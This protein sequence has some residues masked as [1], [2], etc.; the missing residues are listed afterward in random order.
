[1][2]KLP[3]VPRADELIDKA[4]RR[5][6]KKAKN[7]R[8]KRGKKDKKLKDAE[9]ARVN[10]I[11]S[12]IDSDLKKIVNNFPSY[13][14]LPSFYQRLLDLQ[15]DKN[16]YKRCLGS[17]DGVIPIN[18]KLR[19][20]AIGEIKNGNLEES[21]RY[22]GKISSLVEKIEDNLQELR[23]IKYTLQEFPAVE[24]I[25]TLVVAGYPNAGKSTF[26]R[27]LT[28]SKVKIAKYPFTTT[29][30]LIG[31][32]ML[33]YFKHQIIDTPGVLD[34]PMEDRNKTEMQ[35]VLAIEELADEVLFIVDPLMDL[36]LQFSL[37]NEIR[38]NFDVPITIAVNKVDMASDEKIQEAREKFETENT[39]SAVNKD[40]CTRIFMDIFNK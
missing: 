8:G 34:R 23:N 9:L 1:M 20:K 22:M 14:Q 30:I 26:T 32:T 21:K 36:Q 4:F 3:Y 37:Y 39:F 13:D 28:G 19:R 10:S 18:R 15:V 24:D 2:F 16:R 17:V 6:R 35:A 40:D 12:I 38:E 11:G 29:S 7:A 33:G 25:P 31:H 5:G 27:S